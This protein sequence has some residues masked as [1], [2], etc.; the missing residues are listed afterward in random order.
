MLTA[1]SVAKLGDRDNFLTLCRAHC[2][3]WIK[4]LSHLLNTHL[5]V[6]DIKVKSSDS[7]ITDLDLQ[8]FF[9]MPPCLAHQFSELK[10]K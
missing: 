5:A 6:T 1:F 3:F 9:M 8:L 4:E 2:F 7:S 10:Q